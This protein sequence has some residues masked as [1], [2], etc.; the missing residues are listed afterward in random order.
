MKYSFIINISLA[1]IRLLSNGAEEN[2]S[3]SPF[4]HSINWIELSSDLLEYIDGMTSS[5]DQVAHWEVP[6]S[7]GIHKIEF[8]HGTTTGKRVIRVDGN[9]IVRRDWMFKLVGN[10]MFE[11]GTAKCVIKVY[12]AWQRNVFN[13]HIAEDDFILYCSCNN[14]IVLCFISFNICF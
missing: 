9:E 13:Y 7:D 11:V 6:L 10:E 4:V 3:M 5:P 12:E 2:K 1:G 8:E 14:Y